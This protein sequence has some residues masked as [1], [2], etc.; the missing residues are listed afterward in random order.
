MHEV[1][2]QRSRERPWGSRGRRFKSCQPDWHKR[3]TLA[4]GPFCVASG[5]PALP[6]GVEDDVHHH[7]DAT[8]VG[9]DVIAPL[10]IRREASE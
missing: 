10:S 3:V 7:D 5:N 6:R 1:A 9:F 2:R 4:G 8:L